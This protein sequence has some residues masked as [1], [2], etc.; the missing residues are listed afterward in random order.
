MTNQT[1]CVLVWLH[2]Q[3]LGVIMRFPPWWEHPP[4]NLSKLHGKVCTFAHTTSVPVCWSS[5]RL[6]YNQP[7]GWSHVG[8]PCLL[9]PGPAFTWSMLSLWMAEAQRGEWKH[10][11]LF[12]PQ[13]G[14]DTLSFCLH[15]TDQNKSYGQ[16]QPQ[17]ARKQTPHTVAQQGWE[18]KGELWTN[19]ITNCIRQAKFVVSI[20]GG[21]EEWRFQSW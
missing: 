10:K 9:I 2:H 16:A 19:N 5:T 18:G 11:H 4:P 21:K 8:S 12:K 7:S 15:S 6:G 20:S 3:L 1:V 17:G 13:V 14:T